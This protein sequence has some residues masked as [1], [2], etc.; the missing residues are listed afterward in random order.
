MLSEV[1]ERIRRLLAASLRQARR[2]ESRRLLR[3]GAA[4][5]SALEGRYADMLAAGPPDPA[6]LVIGRPL[7]APAPSAPVQTP[8]VVGR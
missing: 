1:R 2:Y 4:I 3:S 7:P 8:V 6:T 5:D